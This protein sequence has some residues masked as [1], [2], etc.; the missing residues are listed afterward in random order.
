MLAFAFLDSFLDTLTAYLGDIT[1]TTMRDNF[2]TVY[3]V[4]TNVSPSPI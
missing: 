1:E 4:S 3:M 2:D